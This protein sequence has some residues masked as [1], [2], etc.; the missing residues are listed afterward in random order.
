M[1]A[2]NITVNC[3]A[4]GPTETEMFRSGNPPDAPATK[5]IMA[6]INQALA[7]RQWFYPKDTPWRMALAKKAADNAATIKPQLDDDRGPA[8]YYRALKDIAAWMPKNTVLSAEG[9]GTM[10]IGHF[11]LLMTRP[12]GQKLRWLWRYLFPSRNFLRYRYGERGAA[13]PILTRLLRAGWLMT[14]ASVLAAKIVVRLIMPVSSV[15]HPRP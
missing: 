9:A 4:P 2:H 3:V 10:D 15:D 8:N 12:G 13:Q 6:Q 14:Q 5:A 1:A 7:K 11:L